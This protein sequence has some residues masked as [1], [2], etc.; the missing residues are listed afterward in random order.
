MFVVWYLVG[1][2]CVL[3]SQAVLA[4]AFVGIGLLIRRAFGLTQFDLDDCFVAFWMGFCAIVLLLLL[5]NFVLPVTAAVLLLV[6]CIGAVGLYIT[7]AEFAALANE[8]VWRASRAWKFA[9]VLAALYVANQGLGGLTYSDSA[10]YHLQAVEWN[11]TYPL[12]PGLANLYGP[13][14]FNNASLLYGAML[15]AGPWTGLG[16]R[17]ANGLLLQ[18]LLLRIV[19]ALTRISSGGRRASA[20]EVFIATPPTRGTQPFTVRAPLGIRYGHADS[21]PPPR[22]GRTLV[23]STRNAPAG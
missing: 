18:A 2:V 5:W 14:G 4:G 13:L 11:K 16:H 8:E 15:D 22:R 9:F 10:L 6:L 19:I 12:V 20:H 17:L 3:A 1:V 7:R 23:R 21:D